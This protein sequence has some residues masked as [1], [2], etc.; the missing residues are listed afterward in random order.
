MSPKPAGSEIEY[1]ATCAATFADAPAM[2]AAGDLYGV[3]SLLERVA[4]AGGDPAFGRAARA[5]LGHGGRPS[6]NDDAALAEMARVLDASEAN[7]VEGAAAF[8]AAKLPGRQS[9]LATTKRLARKYR[10]L[11]R[12]KILN[13]STCAEDWV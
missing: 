8:V 2:F 3:A 9:L 10:E 7:T 12:H 6:L 11:G 4:E 13:A 1:P 5:L